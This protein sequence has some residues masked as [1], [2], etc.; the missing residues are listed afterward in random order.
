MDTVLCGPTA[1]RYWRT[2]PIVHLLA[3]APEDHPA[4][5]G[6]VDAEELQAFRMELLAQTKFGRDC[7]GPAW[8]NVSEHSERIRE[9]GAF[10]APFA[11]YPV[12]VLVHD[13][14]KRRST[15]LIRPWLWTQ[16]LPYGAT[17]AIVDELYVTTPAFTLLQLASRASV[18][19][20]LLLASE[21]C[22][23]YAT[24][25]PTTPV[26]IMLQKLIDRGRLRDFGGWRP[27]L[28]GTR[29]LTSLW[30]REPIADPHEL[31][32]MAAEASALRGCATL[33]RAA[34]LVVPM[35][36]SPFET[37][38]GILLG[39]SRRLGGAGFCGYAHNERID[40]SREARL[41]A[42]RAYCSCDIYWP[43][44]LDV[45]CQSARHHDNGTSL[46]SDS[47]R[48]AALELMGVR[49]LPLTYKQLA[50]ESRFAAFTSAVAHALGVKQRPRTA[51]QARA[52][53][54]LRSEVM[55]DWDTLPDVI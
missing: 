28:T 6:L 35:A 53:N 39:L 44:G 32:K 9:Y 13:E 11:S 30:S 29:R 54:Q 22:G 36:A 48:S 20:T 23:G 38:A 24:Y 25:S 10:L 3:S 21:I 41:I 17:T 51:A 45:E 8:R 49:V 2:P 4:L 31:T 47:D 7:T 18:T 26:A 5:R 50:D 19:R 14:K 1:Y 46:L 27:S 42:D 43:N 34:E 55:C 16:E 37:Q 33:R 15:S 40:L 52:A 12:N